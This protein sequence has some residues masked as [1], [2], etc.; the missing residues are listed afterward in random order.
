ML[1]IGEKLKDGTIYAGEH[2]TED[3]YLVCKAKDGP[4]LVP[5]EKA[6]LKSGLFRCPDPEE[7]RLLYVYRRQIGGFAKAWYWSSLEIRE[8]QAWRQGFATGNQHR[9]DKTYVGR[10]RYVRTVTQK[11]LE[12][13]C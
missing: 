3:G 12:D 4:E 2:P 7:L 10:V 8:L 6:V 11:E 13:L 5:W 1:K 9:H